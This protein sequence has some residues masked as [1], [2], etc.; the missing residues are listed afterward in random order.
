MAASDEGPVPRVVVSGVVMDAAGRYLLVRRRDDGLWCCPG[1]HVDYAETVL[2][3]LH[4]EVQEEAGV[5]I[6]VE[7]LVGVYSVFGPSAPVPGK[8]YVALSFLCRHTAGEPRP[9]GD[10]LEARFFGHAEL[11][12]LRSNHR[13]RIDDA[14]AG[15]TSVRVS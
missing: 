9:G 13:A 5:A 10:E 6:E 7:R 2:A 14:R 3:A 12:P 4:R 1:G 8:H 15:L 11:P